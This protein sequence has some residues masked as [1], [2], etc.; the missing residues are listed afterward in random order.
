[1]YIVDINYFPGLSK[2]PGYEHFFVEYL[3]EACS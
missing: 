2:V 3:V 1:M